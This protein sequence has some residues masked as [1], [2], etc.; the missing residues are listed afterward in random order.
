MKTK[1]STCINNIHKPFYYEIYGRNLILKEKDNKTPSCYKYDY[2]YDENNNIVSYN[3][4][5][6]IFVNFKYDENGI[7][8]DESLSGFDL[9][10]FEITYKQ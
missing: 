4:D 3:D 7:L 8:I 1:L 6:G 10:G 2:Y 9:T 5:N